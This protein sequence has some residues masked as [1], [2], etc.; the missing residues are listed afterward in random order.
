[1]GDVPLE[2]WLAQL[3]ARHGADLTFPELRRAVQALSSLYV[4]RRGRIASGAA[5]DT[6]GKRAAF[7]VFFT[8]IHHLLVRAIV[9]ELG[10]A[11]PPPRT[12]VDL[13]CGTGAA[14]SA[15]AIEAGGVPEVCGLDINGWAVEEA[16]RTFAALGVRGRA[17]RGDVARFRP[18]AR[19]SG[20]VA[21]FTVNELAEAARAALLAR[22]LE[23]MRDGVRVLVVEPI[24]RRIAP[25]WSAWSRAFLAAGGRADDWRVSVELPDLVARL[26][27]ASGLDHGELTG[28]SLWLGPR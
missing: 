22:L 26:D 1:M 6:R 25:W 18:P 23:S 19:G 11:L 15:W 3:E 17:E 13:G 27:A 24:S 14:G 9:R 12:I 20:I 8:P 4:E 7:A 28:R 5:L 2:R 10:C 21:A 16:R